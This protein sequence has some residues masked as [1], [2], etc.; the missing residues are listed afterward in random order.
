M[1]VLLT[2]G[3]LAKGLELARALS[4]AGHRVVIAEP[5]KWHLAKPSSAI[6]KSYQVTAPV[7]NLEAYL[8]ELLEIVRRE[9]IDLVIPIS[10]EALYAS[11]IGPMLPSGTK[12]FGPQ[13]QQMANLHDKLKFA[14]TCR[15]RGLTSP[16]THRANTPEA[17]ALAQRTD[18]VV[19]PIHGCSGIGLRLSEQGA[20]LEVADQSP[21]NLVQERLYGRQISSFSIVKDGQVLATGL[22][23]GDIY[24]GTVSVRFKRVDDLPVVNDWI[25]KF[26]ASENYSG[27]I[28]FDFF[29]TE[30]GTP[31]AIECNPRLTS[32]IHVLNP[33]AVAA[34]VAG[35]AFTG[36]IYRSRA[37]F[38]D[39]HSALTVAIGMITKPLSYFKLLGKVLTTKD[40]I[41]DWR[42]PLP[43]FL[44]TPMSWDTLRQGLF[45]GIP[46]ADAVT[47]DILWHGQDQLPA[48]QAPREVSLDDALPER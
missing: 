14:Q 33:K 45:E 30:D 41:F 13:F 48:I 26:V 21:D 18:Y 16:E 37:S 43:F 19:K 4:R 34:M 32:G 39:A 28:S 36:A 7:E 6:A 10:E 22:Y 8:D 3:R 11:R 42:D 23:E 12:L 24:L 5:F 20:Q 25:S 44:M 38:Q 17:R 9:Q 46:L 31:F 35:D 47:R 15:A 1:N 29:V 27:F 40:V 2:L